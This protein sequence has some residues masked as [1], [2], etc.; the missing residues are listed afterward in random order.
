LVLRLRGG[1]G[2][3]GTPKKQPQKRAT[4]EEEAV[5]EEPIRIEIT[6]NNGRVMFFKTPS[7]GLTVGELKERVR[8]KLNLEAGEELTLTLRGI[9][10]IPV[11]Y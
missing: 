6:M 2:K 11:S 3:G 7:N 5:P 4:Q 9:F 10:A 1:K 8:A